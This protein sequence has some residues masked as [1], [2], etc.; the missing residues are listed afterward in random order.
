MQVPLLLKLEQRL[1]LKGKGQGRDQRPGQERGAGHSEGCGEGPRV[2]VGPSGLSDR[3]EDPLWEGREP[4][5]VDW[6][7]LVMNRAPG[8][9]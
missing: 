9:H 7:W 2:C 4:Q 8:S 6:A 3:P 5:R 1:R